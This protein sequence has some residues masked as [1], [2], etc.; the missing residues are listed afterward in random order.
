M[1]KRK[2]PSK[3]LEKLPR[4]IKAPT[5]KDLKPSPQEQQL[6]QELFDWEKNSRRRCELGM[7]PFDMKYK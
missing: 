6:I 5:A 1:A 2:K 4:I 7:P 3:K